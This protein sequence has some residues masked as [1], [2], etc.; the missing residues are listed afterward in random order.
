[1]RSK[2]SQPDRQSY[3]TAILR[4]AQRDQAMRQQYLAD[5]GAWDASLDANSTEFLRTI[6]AA[7]GWPTLRMVGSKAS[8]AASI[9]LS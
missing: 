2:Q 1:M 8:T 3:R 9:A 7:I 4:Y 5:G 6:V